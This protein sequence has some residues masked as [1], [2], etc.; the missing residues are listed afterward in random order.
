MLRWHAVCSGGKGFVLF[1]S[2]VTAA[3]GN[4]QID[5]WRGLSSVT[6]HDDRVVVL[7]VGTDLASSVISCQLLGKL[8]S[9]PINT[10]S[11]QHWTLR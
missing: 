6:W 11:G 5:A 4:A 10:D 2:A 1:L 9:L 8:R 7:E 3:R